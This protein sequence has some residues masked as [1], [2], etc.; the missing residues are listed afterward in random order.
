MSDFPASGPSGRGP[1]GEMATVTALLSDGRAMSGRG[2]RARNREVESARSRPV[3]S[4]FST[5]PL[6][7]AT[8]DPRRRGGCGGLYGPRESSGLQ[9]FRGLAP[10]GPWLARGRESDPRARSPARRATGSRRARPGIRGRRQIARRT[11][12]P[13]KCATWSRRSAPMAGVEIASTR[14]PPSGPCAGTMA[15]ESLDGGCWRRGD[16]RDPRFP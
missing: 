16:P 8:G 4:V 3:V 9:R 10:T 13:A 6:D 12:R 2:R 1:T 5:V 11:M 7:P 15:A 14:R